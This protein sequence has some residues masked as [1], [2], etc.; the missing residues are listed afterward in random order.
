MRLGGLSVNKCLS[1]SERKRLRVNDYAVQNVIARL[2]FVDEKIPVAILKKL[3]NINKLRVHYY[4]YK[5]GFLSHVKK[6]IL[7]NINVLIAI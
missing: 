6:I 5:I 4:I 1:C 3:L 7:F 2:N